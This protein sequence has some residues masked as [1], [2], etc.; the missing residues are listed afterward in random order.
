M[1]L[2]RF[3]KSDVQQLI[4]SAK[5]YHELFGAVV[6]VVCVGLPNRGRNKPNLDSI[7]FSRGT[8]AL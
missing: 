1:A 2:L 8:A 5:T 7:P 3:I 6:V 4:E